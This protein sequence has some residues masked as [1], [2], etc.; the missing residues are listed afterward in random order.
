MHISEFLGKI[1]FL[2]ARDRLGITPSYSQEGEDKILDR[3]LESKK[4]GFYVDVGAFHPSRFSNTYCF[5]LRGWRGINIDATPG[6]MRAF[7]KLR[8]RDINLELAISNSSKK[9]TYYSFNE[10]AL[11]GFDKRLS[12]QRNKL[13]EYRI[14]SKRKIKP[15]FLS[16][17]LDEYLPGGQE[18]D[19]MNI[20]AEGW[21]YK[22]LR[23]NNWTKYKPKVILIENLKCQSIDGIGKSGI[24]SF[25]IK[26]GYEFR[27]KTMNTLFFMLKGGED[28]TV[29]P[30]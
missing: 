18:I 6:N 13:K 29:Q 17:I 23:S 4:T 19:F 16:D 11:N 9:M 30:Q 28:G 10:P 8:S 20:D 24:A 15:V 21:D 14:V 22:V 7:N 2:F 25:L 12:L 3:L 27:A 5:Y 26:R 1:A